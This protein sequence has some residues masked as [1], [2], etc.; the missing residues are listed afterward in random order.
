MGL[1]ANTVKNGIFTIDSVDFSNHVVSGGTVTATSGNAGL[2][3]GEVKDGATL[4]VGSLNN[5]PTATI[6]SKSGC[7]GGVVGK[8]GW[9]TGATVEVTSAIDLSNLTVKGTAAAGGFIGQAIKLTLT[10]NEGAKV[11]CPETVGDATSGNVGGFIGEV[12]FCSSVEFTGN[13]Q[14][15]M[16]NEGVTLAGKSNESNGV[17]AAIGKLNFD[18]STVTVSFNGG[19][20]KS[21]YGNGGGTAVFGGL[22]GSVT[23]RAN[24]KPLRIESVTTEF[25]LEASPNFTGGLVGWLGRGTGATLE[26]KNATVNCTQLR[27]S[28]KG[29]GGVAGCIDNKSIADIN[30]VTVKNEGAIENGAG[31][32]A[33]SWGSAIRLGG[34]TDFSGMKFDPDNS[35]VGKK[36]V[37]QIANVSAGNPTLVFACGTGSD[38]VPSDANNN[39]DYWVYKRCPQTKIDDLGSDQNAD[40]GYGEVIRLDDK[41]LPKNLI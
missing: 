36:V 31:I 13:D 9:N 33:E 21:A 23:G 18:N 1:L 8:V 30:G 40:C 22:V 6:E 34:V 39:G 35:F 37:S 2:L 5:V 3:V 17:G 14:I 15:D 25:A 10:Q 19:T 16:G 38:S 28:S 24:S 11:T 20:F 29:F 32:A 27:Q 26:V 4:R 12:S 7:A 41:K